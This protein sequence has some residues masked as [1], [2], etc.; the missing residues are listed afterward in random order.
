MARALPAVLASALLCLAG[1]G[2]AAELIPHHAFYN[3]KLGT[4]S[5][6]SAIVEAS[7]GMAIEVSE[8]CDAWLTKQRL[9]LRI[10]RDEGD[11]VVTDN[12]FTSWEAKDGLKYRFSVRNRLNGEVNEEFRGEAELKPNGGAG[13]AIFTQ[14]KR[15]EVALPKG[16]LFPTAHVAA[17]IDAARKGTRVYRRVVF[18]GATVDGPE[19]INAVLGK[20]KPLG[21][22]PGLEKKVESP[23][24]PMR[25]AFFPIA[26][27]SPAPDYEIDMRM[28][29][30]GVVV[31]VGLVYEDF[32][33]S[34]NVEYFEPLPRPK[35]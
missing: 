11:E 19:E 23:S 13:K 10:L 30:D 5:G 21:T 25:W 18:D 16:T 1:P 9:R 7:G 12:N 15:S 14:P 6:Q 29:D 27:K 32:E 35:C 31:D 3:L 24:W 33:V 28:L 34:G 8:T 4:K 20:P 22:L 26:S 17:L 2:G